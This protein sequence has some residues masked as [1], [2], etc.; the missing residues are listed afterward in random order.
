MK[1]HLNESFTSSIGNNKMY[2]ASFLEFRM[3]TNINM[4]QCIYIIRLHR[5]NDFSNHIRQSKSCLACTSLS[6]LVLAANSRVPQVLPGTT[7]YRLIIRGKDKEKKDAIGGKGKKLFF[8][9]LLQNYLLIIK[10]TC[11]DTF[12]TTH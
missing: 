5:R 3:I 8:S 6:T 7:S 9:I 2:C 4:N 10:Q 12:E 11:I 1:N